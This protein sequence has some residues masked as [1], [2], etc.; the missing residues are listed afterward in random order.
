[1]VRKYIFG[2]VCYIASVILFITPFLILYNIK[3]DV[4]IVEAEGFDIAVG[5][6]IGIVYLVLVFKGLLKKA[7]PLMSVFITTVVLAI[8]IGLLDS[9]INDLFWIMISVSIGVL[10][11]VIFYKIGH[12][13]IEL[14]KIYGN[15]KVRMVAREEATSGR[16]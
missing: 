2:F 11:F 15:E 7:A 13:Q 14:A 4:W 3:R 1:M 6:I 16:V 12:R 5:V 10:L 9:I 8:I